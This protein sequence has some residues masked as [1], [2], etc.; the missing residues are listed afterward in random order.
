MFNKHLFFITIKKIIKN[1]DNINLIES[2]SELK[3]MKNID[4]NSMVKIMQ[5]VFKTIIAKKYG[6]ADNFDIIVNPN[7]G[8]LE[9]W[10]N[11]IVVE[12]SYE[13]FDENL[14]IRI[15]DANRIEDGFELG[16]DFTDE[17]KIADIGRRSISTIRQFL[18]S[19]ILDLGKQNIYKKYKERE[20]EIIVGEVH[21]VTRKEVVILDDEG[22]EFILPRTEQVPGDYFRKGDSV[23]ALL[24]S[25]EID[26]G[27]LHMILSRTSNKF[28][29]K[30]FEYEIPEVFD[31]LVIIKGVVR[32]PGKKAKVAVES[33]DDRV[34]VVGTCV[35]VK[36]GKI[37]PIV[38]ELNNENIDIINYTTNSSLYVMRAL[39]NMKCDVTIDNVTKR[40]IVTMP[41]EFIS[42]SIGKGGL[43]I[44]LASKL[45]G[46]KIDLYS[47]DI[48]DEDVHLDDFIDE[49][50]GW[51]IDQLK[52]IGCDTAKSVLKHS[53]SELVKRT[54]LEEETIREV[55]NILSSEFE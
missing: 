53:V 11:R 15:T 35:G 10:R 45:T 43:N 29:E 8:D 55:I 33:Y 24:K 25:V 38:R 30:L 28:M 54:D 49:I 46:Y 27:K 52:E 36:G 51:I 32:E 13:D 34:D 1:M 21:Q 5:E 17:L 48:S 7:K 4:K 23:R 44:K 39:G 26:A 2:F 42:S 40:A 9:I 50:D 19:K 18:K 41:S 31:G 16:E 3:D 20:N 14:H 6:T 12:D 47:D 37:L 22:A